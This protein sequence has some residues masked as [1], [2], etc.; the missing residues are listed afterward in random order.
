MYRGDPRDGKDPACSRIDEARKNEKPV[1]SLS[2]HRS[3]LEMAI[4]T[5][6]EKKKYL[7]G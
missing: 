7:E 4:A 6:E 5:L 2:P 1:F 3:V